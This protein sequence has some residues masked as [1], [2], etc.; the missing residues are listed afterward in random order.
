MQSTLLALTERLEPRTNFS[1][2][3]QSPWAV[4]DVFHKL[5]RDEWEMHRNTRRIVSS[6]HLS[7]PAQKN[8]VEP[9]SLLANDA[10]NFGSS[11]E[12]LVANP[13]RHE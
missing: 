9:S 1:I 6:I 10:S 13:D 3:T 12:H 2:I 11:S 5:T 8:F 4:K 7:E